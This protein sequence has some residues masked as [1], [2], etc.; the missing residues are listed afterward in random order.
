MLVIMQVMLMVSTRQELQVWFGDQLCLY[1]SS[2]CFINFL[3]L[4]VILLG[5]G[6]LDGSAHFRSF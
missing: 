4:A 1:P 6:D 2:K 5:F 3:S